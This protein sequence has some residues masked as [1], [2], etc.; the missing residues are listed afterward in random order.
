MVDAW[1]YLAAERHI[2][3]TASGSMMGGLPVNR[4][5]ARAGALLRP[6]V[7]QRRELRN[8]PVIE[9][10]IQLPRKHQMKSSAGVPAHPAR[11]QPGIIKATSAFH[12][13]D[14][15]RKLPLHS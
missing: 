7:N 6:A 8:H 4:S 9:A 5:D 14:R 13:M 2:G 15:Q 12:H 11:E 1:G 10:L 3:H